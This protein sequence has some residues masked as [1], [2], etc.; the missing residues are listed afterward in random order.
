MTAGISLMTGEF[1]GSITG[2]FFADQ[3]VPHER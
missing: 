1:S 2:I 3:V